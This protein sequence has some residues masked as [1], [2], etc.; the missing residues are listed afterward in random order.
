MCVYLWVVR[1]WWACLELREAEGEGE[2]GG[3]SRGLG[4]RRGGRPLAAG[5]AGY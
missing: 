4:R 5:L 3:C 2:A 1:V